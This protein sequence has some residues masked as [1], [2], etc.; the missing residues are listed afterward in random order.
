MNKRT[1][2]RLF[3]EFV[4]GKISTIYFWEVYKNNVEL[5]EILIKDKKRKKGKTKEKINGQT[6]IVYLDDKSFN[7]NPDNLLTKIDIRRLGDR[8]ALF[9]VIRRFL[10]MRGI[11]FKEC[12][13][14]KDYQRYW[15][16]YSM[17]PDYVDVDDISYLEK[18]YS[19]A[20]TKY[21]ETEKM[22][23]CKKKIKELFVFDNKE[24]EWYQAADWPIVDGVPLVFSHQETTDEGIERY[25]F[26]DKNTKEVMIIEQ[27]E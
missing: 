11:R 12:E 14:N 4:T 25:Y 26:Y 8:Y 6:V 24:P 10:N 22:S 3:R 13:Y 15:F 20:P 1:S 5:Q 19:E 16:L 27:I 17:L 21:N 7:V 9:C 18:I 2:I 23:W